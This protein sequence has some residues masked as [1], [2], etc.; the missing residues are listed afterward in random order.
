LFFQNFA[1]AGNSAARADTGYK[2]INFSFCI[3]PYFFGGGSA[4]R[5][6]GIY[7]PGFPL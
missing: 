4:V 2:N 5:F 7:A 1:Y 3:R 6:G